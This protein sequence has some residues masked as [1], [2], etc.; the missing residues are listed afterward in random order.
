MN[1][2]IDTCTLLGKYNNKDVYLYTSAEYEAPR[3]FYN[4]NYYFLPKRSNAF[5]SSISR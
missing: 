4:P 2:F 3:I 1:K 5:F